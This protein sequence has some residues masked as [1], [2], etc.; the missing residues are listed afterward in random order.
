[1]VNTHDIDSGSG[2][3]VMIANAENQ[4]RPKELKN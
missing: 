2:A 3:N 4:D 1:M